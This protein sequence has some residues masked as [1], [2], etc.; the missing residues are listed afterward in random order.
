[1]SHVT[2]KQAY[3]PLA[4]FIGHWK[5]AYAELGITSQR[6]PSLARIADETNISHGVLRQYAMRS[7]PRQI[8]RDNATVIADRYHLSLAWI[9]GDIPSNKPLNPDEKE[10]TLPDLG[11]GYGMRGTTEETHSSERETVFIRC[12][13]EQACKKISRGFSTSMFDPPT[14]ED[15][16]NIYYRILYLP[17]NG[18]VSKP[19]SKAELKRLSDNYA[20][21]KQ[22]ASSARNVAES[23]EEAIL[24]NKMTD[25]TASQL[26]QAIESNARRLIALWGKISKEPLSQFLEKHIAKQRSN[27]PRLPRKDIL[28]LLEHFM[29]DAGSHPASPFIAKEIIESIYKIRRKYGLGKSSQPLDEKRKKEIVEKAK[30]GEGLLNLPSIPG[31]VE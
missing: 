18:V 16:V 26:N 9:I 28:N 10:W 5:N 1:M 25:G 30:K 24:A 12:A 8:G 7:N 20:L 27:T 2:K 23:K 29:A 3:P 15:W 4:R 6:V 31:W 22:K 19:A 21:V 13:M 17:T 11:R 14:R